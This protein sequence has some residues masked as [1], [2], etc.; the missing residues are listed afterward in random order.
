MK[1]T[2]RK[3]DTMRRAFGAVANHV[4]IAALRQNA[5]KH[6]HS[7]TRLLWDVW[8]EASSQLRYDDTHPRWRTRT[9]CVPCD[10]SFDAY[11]DGCA[12]SHIETALR[13]I[14]REVGLID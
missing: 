8:H 12:D 4:G 10:V 1:I 14:A 13:V 9:R 6:G 3:L 7:Q 5:A 2:G 11:T